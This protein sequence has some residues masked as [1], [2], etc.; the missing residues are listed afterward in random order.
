M[1]ILQQEW[2]AVN[3][4]LLSVYIFVFIS[5]GMLFASKTNSRLPVNRQQAFS[6][7]I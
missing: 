3:K 5:A 6:M 4:R 7:L 1:Y 2:R